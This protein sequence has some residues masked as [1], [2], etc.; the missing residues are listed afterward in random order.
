MNPESG[1]TSY[2]YYPGGQVWTKTGGNAVVTTLT[3]D[4]AR[5]LLTKSYNDGTPAVRYC[6]DGERYSNGSCVADVSSRSVDGADFPKG[7]LTG[8]GNSI[9]ATNYERVDALGR[10]TRVR[11]SVD[12]LAGDAV[13]SY[14]YGSGGARKSM[15]YPSGRMVNYSLGDSGKATQLSGTF[16]GG[17]TTYASAM[18]YAPGGAVLSSNLAGGSLLEKRNYNELGQATQIEVKRGTQLI[19]RL[20]YS[21]PAVGNNGNVSSHSSTTPQRTWNQYFGYDSA[22]RLRLAMERSAGAP[23]DPSSGS[24][25]GTQVTWT[26]GEWCQ[27]FGFDGFGNAWSAE[28]FGAT[29]LVANGASWF[30]GSTNRYLNVGYDGAGNQTQLQVNSPQLVTD[31]D[32]EG[33][34]LRRRNTQLGTT[35]F[36]YGYGGGGQRVRKS[37][38]GVVTR[39]AYGADGE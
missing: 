33:R 4:G 34:I 29:P 17:G 2:T 26:G 12:G 6:Y 38:G 30:V 13:I 27:Q 35:L 25:S 16:A 10:V 19:H 21:Y 39:Y 36:E 5:R 8:Y 24:C 28:N 23:A 9:A 15:T 31:Y 11:Q 1:T 14:T 18:Q 37:V 7:Q 3:Y 32:G 22:N 20:G